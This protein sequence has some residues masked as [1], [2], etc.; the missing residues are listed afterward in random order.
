[1]KHNFPLSHSLSIL[2]TA[3]A[4]LERDMNV[5]QSKK[6]SAFGLF[7]PVTGVFPHWFQETNPACVNGL[8]FKYSWYMMGQQIISLSG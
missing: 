1:M 8:L 5:Y 6:C 4:L 7:W 2:L 3:G